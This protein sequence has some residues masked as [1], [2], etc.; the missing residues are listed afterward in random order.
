MNDPWRPAADT[1]P[2]DKPQADTPP[3]DMPE[4]DSSQADTPEAD[5]S[6]ADVPPADSSPADM[7]QA[8]MAAARPSVEAASAEHQPRFGAIDIV[9]AFVALRHELKL[10]V[11]NGREIRDATTERLGRLEHSFQG[12]IREVE[13][14]AGATAQ[15]SAGDDS[16]RSIAEALAET[17]ESLDRAVTALERTPTAEASLPGID[18]ESVLETRRRA[19]PR[20]LR[21]FAKSWCHETLAAVRSAVQEQQQVQAAEQARRQA[22][23]EGFSLL[24]DRVRRL[25][26]SS[27]IRRIDVEGTPFDPERMKALES[28]RTGDCPPGHVA[29]QLRPGYLWN[30]T[31]LRWAEVRIESAAADRPSP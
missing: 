29:E 17:E 28:V 23:L 22:V 18:L 12:L 15:A 2:A 30:D 3:A 25:L 13:R 4:A 20:L 10:Q 14:L 8:D 31:I 9:N 27:G 16:A 24:R 11:R 19:L 1:P 7:P 5:M 21:R 26:V 6:P